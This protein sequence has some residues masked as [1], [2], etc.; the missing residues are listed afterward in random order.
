M[1]GVRGLLSYILCAMRARPGCGLMCDHVPCMWVMAQHELASDR[2][3]SGGLQ[4]YGEVLM[5]HT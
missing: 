2:Q 1:A 3:S 4:Q 5:V